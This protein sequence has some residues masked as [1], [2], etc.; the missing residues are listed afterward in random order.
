MKKKK[1]M[2]DLLWIGLSVKIGLS[3]FME[4][5]KKIRNTKKPYLFFF[6]LS[7]LETQTS[8]DT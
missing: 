1:L 4:Q 5:K 8:L 7:S 6:I 2:I 3:F